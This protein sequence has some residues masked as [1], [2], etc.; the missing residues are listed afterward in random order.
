MRKRTGVTLVRGMITGFIFTFHPPG[1]IFSWIR[2]PQLF[3]TSPQCMIELPTWSVP[4]SSFTHS[5]CHR[6]FTN[7]T[8]HCPFT[9]LTDHRPFAS[10]SCHQPFTNSTYH[11]LFTKSSCLCQFTAINAPIHYQPSTDVHS[12]SFTSNYTFVFTHSF[13]YIYIY[14][15]YTFIYQMH[16]KKC[17]PVH[18]VCLPLI[19]CIF[20]EHSS[21]CLCPPSHPIQFSSINLKMSSIHLAVLVLSH[22]T[23]WSSM[24]FFIVCTTF[25][26]IQSFITFTT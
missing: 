14:I 25:P 20:S 8:F 26:S 4:T 3:I 22:S 24:F 15:L 21:M 13:K 16:Y 5:S 11:R 2:L 18:Y 17:N 1:G 12:F 10:S 9:S 6:P 23:I 7:S 19:G